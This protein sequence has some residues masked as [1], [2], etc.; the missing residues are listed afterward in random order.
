M[1][2]KNIFNQTCMF[3]NCDL[4]ET[5]SK[6]QLNDDIEKI[7]NL[8]NNIDCESYV[9]KSENNLKNKNKDSFNYWGAGSEKENLS[10][11]SEISEGD[12]KSLDDSTELYI[13][14]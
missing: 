12:E 7:N 8:E 13:I 3:K 5:F 1:L 2:N 11:V 6:I 9:K 4:L 10:I 14:L